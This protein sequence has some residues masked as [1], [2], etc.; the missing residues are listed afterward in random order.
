MKILGIELQ[1]IVPEAG[2]DNPHIHKVMRKCSGI[3]KACREI[4]GVSLKPSTKC[5]EMAKITD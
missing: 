1:T 4:S 2:T 5:F 3:R